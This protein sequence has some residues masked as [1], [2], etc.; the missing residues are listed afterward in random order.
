MPATTPI[1]IRLD[2]PGSRALRKGRVS[3]AGNAYLVTTV[4]RERKSIFDDFAAGCAAARCFEDRLVLGDASMLAWVLM[5]NHAHWLIRLGGG[6]ALDTVVNRLKSA[7][8]R[9]VN[10]ELHRC[11]PVWARGYH[12]HAMRA[13]EDLRRSA[14]YVIAHPVRAAL[15]RQVGEYPFWNAVWL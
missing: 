9:H 8:A 3:I 5:P 7:S 4:V 2:G 11:G 12:D 6:D 13:E 15:V 1:S 14:R 10:R